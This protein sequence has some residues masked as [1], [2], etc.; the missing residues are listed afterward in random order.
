MIN[1]NKFLGF[2]A[3]IAMLTQFSCVEDVPVSEITNVPFDVQS[4]STPNINSSE[5]NT[6]YTVD[7]TL[8]EGQIVN[9][10]VDITLD[11]A[12]TTATNGV[13]FNFSPIS[14]E[15]PAYVRN[16]SFTFEVLEDLAAEG[17]ETIRF[18]IGPH[19]APFS[20]ASSHEVNVNIKDSIYNDVRISFDWEGT[21][22]ID[23][24]TYPICPNVDMDFYVFQ[25]GEG[26][27]V[28]GAATGACPELLII[29]NTVLPDGV[30]D[31]MS[32]LYN[33]ELDGYGLA[34][35]YPIT[36]TAT[37][38]GVFSTTFTPTEVWTS[39]DTDAVHGMEYLFKPAVQLEVAGSTYTLRD[40]A[41]EVIISG[42]TSPKTVE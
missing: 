31:I 38:G 29:D 27:G 6:T 21:F 11:E 3:S 39:D 25:G 2:L 9:T 42:F 18:I 10:I 28:Y 13:D 34:V 4:I 16:G 36:I 8:D 23:G 1:K 14:V 30:Y 7:F 40:I 24:T 32:Q 15:I 20:I 37:K 5:S 33:N 26:Q 12:N 22:E 19:D 17:D 41:G 35:P